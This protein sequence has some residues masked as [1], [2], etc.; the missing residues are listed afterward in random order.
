MMT[1]T[2][3]LTQLE[4]TVLEALRENAADCSG[5][6]FA[7]LEEVHVKGLGRQALGGV[8]T[9][10]ET[11]GVIRVDVTYVNGG[12]SLNKYGQRRERNGMKVTQVTFR[13]EKE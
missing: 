7:C 10:L 4:Q 11:K 1:Q 3:T 9:S 12:Y 6:T 5:G 2:P 13:Q 8:I